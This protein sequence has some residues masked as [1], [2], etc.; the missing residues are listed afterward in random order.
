M[1]RRP[2]RSTLF[3]YTTLFR[4]QFD[5]EPYFEGLRELATNGI[6][7]P[8]LNAFRMLG[9]LGEK[10]LPVT[11]SAA[12][13]AIQIEQEGVR[14]QPDVD[15]IAAQKENEVEVLVVNYHDDDV[16]AQDVL[17]DLN[18]RGLP[19]NAEKIEAELYRVDATHSNSYTLWKQMG[20]PQQPASDS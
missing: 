3:P 19:A 15:A 1:I 7:K 9:L 12:I 8:V 17:V 13:P 20:E 16:S 2:P 14:G 4:S 11:S 5:G 18:V 6:D 10:R